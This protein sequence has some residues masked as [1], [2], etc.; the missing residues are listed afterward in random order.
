M[1]RVIIGTSF[2]T[3]LKSICTY[4]FYIIGDGWT[5]FTVNIEHIYG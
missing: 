2:T 4:G 3:I 5:E 1:T